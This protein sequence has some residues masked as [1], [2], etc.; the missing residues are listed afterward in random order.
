MSNIAN[1]PFLLEEKLVTALD[2]FS[3]SLNN[4][5]NQ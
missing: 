2:W 3:L 1:I 4:L 5:D